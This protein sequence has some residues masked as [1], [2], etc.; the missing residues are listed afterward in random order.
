MAVKHAQVSASAAGRVS[1][2]GKTFS[3]CVILVGL[4]LATHA[5]TP[6]V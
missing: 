3:Q 1:S 5:T 6:H 4:N 2:F